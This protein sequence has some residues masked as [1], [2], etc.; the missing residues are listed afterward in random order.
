MSFFCNPA[1]LSG[2]APTR[3][4]SLLTTCMRRNLFPSSLLSCP[5]VFQRMA[6]TGRISVRVELFGRI[7]PF[8][9]H[10]RH[11]TPQNRVHPILGVERHPT[12]DAIVFLLNLCVV[13]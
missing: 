3:A 12:F 11:K 1:C 7:M 4:C 13:E 9:E 6:V 8:V 2:A 10:A 5:R